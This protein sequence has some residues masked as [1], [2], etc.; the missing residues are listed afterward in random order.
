MKNI[1]KRF[2]YIKMP[3]SNE[4]EETVLSFENQLENLSNENDKLKIL[5]K[6][7]QE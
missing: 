7:I 2:G 5:I 1:K 4:V 3:V 6:T